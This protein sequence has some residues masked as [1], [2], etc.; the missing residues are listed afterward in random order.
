MPK[1][2]VLSHIRARRVARLLACGFAFD[3]SAVDEDVLEA[4]LAYCFTD[5]SSR[6]SMA[7]PDGARRLASLAEY[8]QRFMPCEAAFRFTSAEIFALC[9]ALQI[10]QRFTTSHRDVFSSWEAL[11]VLL[12][13]LAN[14]VRYSLPFCLVLVLFRVLFHA[15]LI[16][17]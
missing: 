10:P 6:V 12:R 7:K 13:R 3:P 17:H 15:L 14:P 4:L 5:I 1:K 2:I 9:D 8:E 11:A 16:S